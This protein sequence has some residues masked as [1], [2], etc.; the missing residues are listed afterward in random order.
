MG[1]F[2]RI[3]H[4]VYRHSVRFLKR[5]AEPGKAEGF[6][7]TKTGGGRWHPL[8]GIGA[9]GVG[10][11][12]WMALCLTALFLAACG[13]DGGGRSQ[14]DF[15][16]IVNP[17]STNLLGFKIRPKDG[18]LTATK[19]QPFDTVKA[20]EWLAT[21]PGGSF[22]YTVSFDESTVSLY[23]IDSKDGGLT[24]V[25]GWFVSP[26]LDPTAVAVT[27]NGSYVYVSNETSNDV[28]GFSVATTT[29]ATL[30]EQTP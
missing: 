25:D 20:Q 7:M 30:T 14:R 8:R 12:R 5:G 6:A 10:S 23:A 22:L 11:G 4:W 17:A 16:Y 15:L 18:A 13:S 3:Y 9:Q 26:S 24:F 2:Y 1:R 27:P 29:Q 19:G 21:H 28:S